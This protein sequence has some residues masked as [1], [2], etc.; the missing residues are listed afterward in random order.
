[1]SKKLPSEGPEKQGSVLTRK[2]N[3]G[4]AMS[5]FNKG[6]L[7]AEFSATGLSFDIEEKPD[8]ENGQDVLENKV[9]VDGPQ[10]EFTAEEQQIVTVSATSV[11]ENPA[12]GLNQK[13]KQETQRDLNLSQREDGLAGVGRIDVAQSGTAQI[14]AEKEKKKKQQ[15]NTNALVTQL[16]SLQNRMGNLLDEYGKNQRRINQGRDI[17]EREDAEAGRKFLENEF[18]IDTEGL[19]DE[20]VLAIVEKKVGEDELTQEGLTQKILDTAQKYEALLKSANPKDNPELLAK[21]EKEF[22]DLKDKAAKYGLDI[23]EALSDARNEH[24]SNK[25][26][27]DVHRNIDTQNRAPKSIT[28]HEES[29]LFAEMAKN[30]PTE[31]GSDQTIS[32]AKQ[33]IKNPI[34]ETP[35]GSLSNLFGKMAVDIPPEPNSSPTAENTVKDAEHSITQISNTPDL[36]I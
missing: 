7:K 11:E 30:T 23:E 21:W 1:M 35:E 12:T 36:K 33:E 19:S 18:E 13:V 25:L 10:A 4:G 8:I 26:L 31:N 9:F 34:K 15:A 24:G 16:I 6:D 29:S 27:K 3:E 17:L 22:E 32:F 2:T 28:E 5:G 20:D 14:N